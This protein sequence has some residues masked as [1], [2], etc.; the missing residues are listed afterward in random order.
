M[1]L[2]A[3]GCHMALL[4][5]WTSFL[6]SNLRADPRNTKCQVYAFNKKFLI[7]QNEAII[8]L[9]QSPVPCVW[10]PV[11]SLAGS[12]AGSSIINWEP[13]DTGHWSSSLHGASGLLSF[14]PQLL[15]SLGITNWKEWPTCLEFGEAEGGSL[16]TVS[17]SKRAEDRV[18]DPYLLLVFCCCNTGPSLP[19]SQIPGRPCETPPVQ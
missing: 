13:A 7:L 2:A 6:C 9:F 12:K 18:G 4:W 14:L 17:S 10:V 8:W 15:P 16:P 5:M 11:V 19:L 3:L 1:L